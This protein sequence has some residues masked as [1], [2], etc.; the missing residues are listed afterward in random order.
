MKKSM[1]TM[2]SSLST[3]ICHAFV[4]DQGFIPPKWG[5]QVVYNQGQ[6]VFIAS[7]GNGAS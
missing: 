6:G 4:K 2:L 3:T 5:H 7:M 1:V